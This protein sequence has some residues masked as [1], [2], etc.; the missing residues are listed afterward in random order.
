MALKSKKN[1]RE[2]RRKEIMMIAAKLFAHKGYADASLSDVA[3]QMDISKAA[4]YHYIQSKEAMLQEICNGLLDAQIK[5]T[6]R[7]QKSNLSPKDKLRWFVRGVVRGAT[8]DRDV[9]HVYF[10]DTN[11][12]SA[13]ARDKVRK[14]KKAFDKVLGLILKEGVEK[15]YVNLRD[16][17]MAVFV[18]QGA[19]I[20][21]YQWYQPNGRLSPEEIAE[22][23]IYLLERLPATE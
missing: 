10:E 14:Q 3:A 9:M 5:E 21:G 23:I 7:L 1:K 4:L 11:S 22:E 15:G 13:D 12:L 19:C 8:K 2:E 17:K 16:I 20:F 6:K 18:I